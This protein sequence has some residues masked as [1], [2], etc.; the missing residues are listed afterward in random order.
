MQPDRAAQAKEASRVDRDAPTR[1]DLLRRFNAMKSE[2]ASWWPHWR[3]ISDNLL[4]RA[5]RY[6]A[7][8]RNRGQ[9]RHNAIYDSS[10]TRALRILAAGMMG[11]MTSPARPWMR[12]STADKDLEKVPAVRQ[13][14]ADVTRLQLVIFHK[15][16]TYR[17]LHSCYMELGAFGTW[18]DV[19][20]D[21]FDTVVH[22]YQITVCEYCI[23]EKLRG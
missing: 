15:S 18:S 22:N 13:W 21:Y 17:A 14:L 4:P 10:G 8:D 11:G 2:R 20:L 7:S 5:G 19:V 1:E 16:N 9:K 3:E 23:F 6:F 12:L